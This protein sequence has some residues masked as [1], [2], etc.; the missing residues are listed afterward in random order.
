MN[1]WRYAERHACSCRPCCDRRPW[2]R[3]RR[4]EAAASQCRGHGDRSNHLGRA[5][6]AGLRDQQ[7]C[8][9]CA[10]QHG[11]CRWSAAQGALDRIRMSSAGLTAERNRQFVAARGDADFGA[12]EWCA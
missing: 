7:G 5:A 8:P 3:E 9:A 12:I 6:E 11:H 10:R 4:D 1:E 2:T